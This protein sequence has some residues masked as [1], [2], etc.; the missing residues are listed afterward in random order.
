MVHSKA[1]AWGAELHLRSCDVYQQSGRGAL[2]CN[3]M[4]CWLN[5][6]TWQVR[7]SVDKPRNLKVYAFVDSN[8]ATNKETRKSGIGYFVTI[9]GCLVSAA[10]KTQPSVTLSSTQAEYIAASMCATEVDFVQMLIEADSRDPIGDSPWG[11]HRC[12]F[13]DGGSGGWQPNKNIDI[14]WHLLRSIMCGE[15]PRLHI[16]FTRLENN[17]ADRR[18]RRIDDVIKWRHV[19]GH[20]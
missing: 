4:T 20:W 13:L 19:A 7:A 1:N 9:G 3:G 14:R 5:C 12:N 6:W 17:M 18:D 15:N 10:L 2:A 11:Q 8:Y 16:V